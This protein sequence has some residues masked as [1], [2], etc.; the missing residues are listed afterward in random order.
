MY[1]SIVNNKKLLEMFFY[2]FKNKI[3]MINNRKAA[4]KLNFSRVNY[5][6]KKSKLIKS[7]SYFK[8]SDFYIYRKNFILD[9]LPLVG[10]K[11][12]A[13]SL[14][15]NSDFFLKYNDY[16][17]DDG[18]LNKSRLERLLFIK[19]SR[20]TSYKDFNKTSRYKKKLLRG[21]NVKNSK[22]K[23]G[24]VNSIS[25]ARLTFFKK[26][27]SFLNSF[28]LKLLLK[29]KYYTLKNTNK[30]ILFKKSIKNNILK[31]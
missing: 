16:L 21:V 18:T 25:L 31:S 10:S 30:K 11:V 20:Y 27:T 5:T 8:H 6:V 9:K 15:N 13:H 17:S 26:N 12:S 22:L 23:R 28:N 29:N 19:Q 4:I 1:N 3:L 14:I 2:F 24:S 7:K